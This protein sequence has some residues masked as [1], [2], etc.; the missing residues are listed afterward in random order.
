MA[1]ME[2]TGGSASGTVVDTSARA[3]PVLQVT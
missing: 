3:E 2:E 1:L